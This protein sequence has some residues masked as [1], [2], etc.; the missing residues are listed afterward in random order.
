MVACDGGGGPAGHPRIFINTDKP[1]I[2][3]CNYCGLP[4]VSRARIAALRR[5]RIGILTNFELQAN[6][7]H[8]QHLEA[9]PQ[10]SY[11]LA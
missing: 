2:S 8:R 6:E 11:P 7:H 3:V 1:E 5:A 10:T 9:L 4:Y